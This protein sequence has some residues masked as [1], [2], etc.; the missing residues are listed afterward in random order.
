LEGKGIKKNANLDEKN[1]D[2]D[3]KGHGKGWPHVGH[4]YCTMLWCFHYETDFA[5]YL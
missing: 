3:V 1:H 5:K 4:E 2:G